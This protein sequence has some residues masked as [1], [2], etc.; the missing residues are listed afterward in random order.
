M[1][2]PTWVDGN[3]LPASDIN[4]WFVPRAA[5]RT[6]TQSV[7]SSTVLVNDNQLSVTVDANAV[8]DVRLF[9]HYTA[10]AASDIQIA[11]TQPAGSTHSNTYLHGFTVGAVSGTDDAISAA[12]TNP[13][14]GGIGSGT[15][16]ALQWESVLTTAGT[17]G[18]L[19][20]QFA[21][22]TSGATATSVLAGSK[23][24]LQRI[25]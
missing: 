2:I 6:S 1:P 22:A 3:P 7:T 5:V 20:V 9:Y 18:T 24:I 11:F 12:A 19:Q 16:A 25:G 4:A 13:A 17:A 15:D 14:L 23:L 8:Y 10:N 21:Q